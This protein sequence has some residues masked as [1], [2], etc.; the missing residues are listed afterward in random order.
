MA[1]FSQP[2]NQFVEIAYVPVF[3]KTSV[4]IGLSDLRP[5]TQYETVDAVSINTM[6]AGDATGCL[7]RSSIQLYLMPFHQS[8]G[9]YQG[10]KENPFILL[11]Q[12]KTGDSNEYTRPP[13]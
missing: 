10:Q 2:L 1:R 6:N 5:R 9:T 12:G 3:S 7:A 11:L 8:E 13:R 4:R